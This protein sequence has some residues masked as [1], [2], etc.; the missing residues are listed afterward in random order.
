MTDMKKIITLLMAFLLLAV[1]A[2]AFAQKKGKGADYQEV[3][4]ATN[5]HCEKCVKK[6]SATL[7]YEKGIKDCKI[8]LD[9]KTI[10]FKFDSRKT[11]REKLAG[12]IRKLGYTA[13]EIETAPKHK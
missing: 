11:S 13:T 12:A 8:D 6:C 1:S 5:L 3:T 9:S 4:F 2:D 10:Y 7:P